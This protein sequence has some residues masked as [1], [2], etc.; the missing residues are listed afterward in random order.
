MGNGYLDK[1]YAARSASETRALYDGWS[2]SYEAEVA[3]NGYVTPGRCAEA[4][5]RFTRDQTLPVFDFG[6]GTG[7][8]GLALKL[9]GFSTIDG[10][11]LSADMLSQAR[12]KRLYRTLTQVE[13]DAPL[14]FARGEY[15]AIAAIGVIGAGAAPISVLDVLMKA[16]SPGGLLVLSLNDHAL[17]DRVN[18]GRINEWIDCAAARLLFREHGPHLPGINLKSTVYVLEKL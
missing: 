8:S 3:E 7:L 11:D 9:A 2:K 1:V 6:C 17:Q 4:L 5:A 13:A 15:A 16:L 14:P 12:A 10:A 18:E